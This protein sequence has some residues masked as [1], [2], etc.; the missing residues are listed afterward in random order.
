MC[1]NRFIVQSKVYDAFTQKLTEAVRKLRVGDGLKGETDQGPLIDAK[2]LAKV[3]EHVADAKS[4]G[5]SVVT[6]GKRHALGGTFYEPTV[7]TNVIA[8]T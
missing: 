6:G 5:A 1:A 2:A 7:L 4:K 8:R 3:E